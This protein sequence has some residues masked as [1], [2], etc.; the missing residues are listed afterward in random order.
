MLF[1][2]QLPFLYR[3]HRYQQ[4]YM[5]KDTCIILNEIIISSREGIMVCEKILN[6][7]KMGMLVNLV[8]FYQL[9]DFNPSVW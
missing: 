4:S 9:Y 3:K 5:G 8:N 1:S 6:V 2:S 7:K